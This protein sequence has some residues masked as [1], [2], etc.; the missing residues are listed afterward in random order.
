MLW[1]LVGRIEEEGELT[2]YAGKIPQE[3]ESMNKAFAACLPYRSMG[4]TET[5]GE[6]SPFMTPASA[7]IQLYGHEHFTG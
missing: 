1:N 7:A 4:E 5:M 2:T 3:P 6:T